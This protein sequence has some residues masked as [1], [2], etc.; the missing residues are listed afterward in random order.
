MA[1]RTEKPSLEELRQYHE[2]DKQ[3]AAREQFLRKHRHRYP[4]RKLDQL[5][6][7]S[8]VWTN[9]VFMGTR[10]GEQLTQKVHEMAEGIDI[11][12]MPS[13]ELVPGA[14]A[15]KKRRATNDGEQPPKKSASKFGP[16]PRF[17]PVHFVV[18][19]VEDDKK[20]IP[21]KD[22]SDRCFPAED[23]ILN[24]S[25]SQMVPQS[26]YSFT[27]DEVYVTEEDCEPEQN[28]SNVKEQSRHEPGTFMSKIEQ[29]YTA[30]Y[31]SHYS[32]MSKDFR[33]NVLDT[34]TDVNKP[35][36]K[37][38]G[39]VKTPHKPGRCMQGQ[40]NHSLQNSEKSTF[41]KQLSAVVRQKMGAYHKDDKHINY[42]CM[43]SSSI[44]DCKKN[45]EYTYVS[46]KE[47]H[48]LDLPENY[49]PQSSG[50]ACEVRCQDIYLA[51]G[52]SG[53]K[54]GARDKA[55]KNAIQ[56]L[57]KPVE[58]IAVSRKFGHAY[59]DDFVVWLTNTPFKELPPALKLH[60]GTELSPFNQ[61]GSDLVKGGSSSKTWSDFILTEN[62]CDAIGILNNSARFNK[63]TVGY[64]YD[65]GPGNT[66]RC[67]VYVQDH[68]V[69]DGYGTKKSSKHAAAEAAVQILKNQQS[70]L[71]K[72][73]Y[74][75]PPSNETA[76]LKDIMIYENTSNPVCTLNNTA[77]FNKVT[78]EYVFEK[79]EGLNWKCKVFMEQTFLA[80]AV[81]VRK[82][83]KHLAAEE[84][85]KALKKTQPVL[86]NNIKNG[87]VQD[88]IS[89]QQIHGWSK[90]E[91][92]KQQIKE[93]NIGNQLLRKMGWTGGGLGKAGEGIAEPI[94]VTE[95]FHREGL[96]L[97]S[98]KH[99]I[100][101]RD[102]E[103]IIR[104]YASSHNQ[105]DLTFSRGLSNEERKLIH[106]LA[107]RFGLKSRSHGQGEERFL[108]VSRKRSKQ[109]LLNELR[110]QGQVGSYALVL[111][112]EEHHL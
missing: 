26:S 108:V 5:I 106:Q 74:T 102:L 52:Y 112:E 92:S 19:T 89:R 88:A 35:G 63:M 59:I 67:S 82:A 70:K 45:P 95:Q 31:E 49:R 28:S 4:G 1:G 107:L 55:A 76:E 50:Y 78:V 101:K 73:S 27:S 42:T 69:A 85:V 68:Y 3:W 91:A 96:G 9:I 47:I 104:V 6:A 14:K 99:K 40:G 30:K 62:A 66:W 32:E 53:S 64:T 56:L 38:I 60:S 90:K 17:Q 23:G 111:P 36:R 10:Y 77:Q 24:R 80:E 75:Q 20:F 33:S 51:T 97:V 87:P 21:T 18:S 105:D 15:S 61:Q 58:V 93:D 54:N 100:N 94:S 110:R 7:L 84:A 11:G 39:F 8:V 103:Q 13:F 44:Q 81:G 16:R 48:P 98:N 71:Q 83:V 2:S 109:D 22:N 79:E 46:L 57:Q 34:W 41:I 12:E 72:T 29:N 37:G 43:L 65:A 86:I 25:T